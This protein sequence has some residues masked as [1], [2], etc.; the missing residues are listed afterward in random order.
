MQEMFEA[1]PFTFGEQP[2]GGPEEAGD[3]LSEGS[4]KAWKLQDKPSEP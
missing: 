1:T 2:S 4:R 3:Q